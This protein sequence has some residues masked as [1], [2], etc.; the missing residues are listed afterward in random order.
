MAI[1]IKSIT[2]TFAITQIANVTNGKTLP[3]YGSV[4]DAS[5]YFSARLYTE[6]WF[7]CER[8]QQ[9]AALSDASRRIDRLNFIGSRAE[10]GQLLEFPRLGQTF[11]PVQIEQATYELA[12]IMLS[13]VDPDTEAGNLSTVTRGYGSM[14]TEYLRT[15]AVPNVKAGIPSM[16]AWNLLVPYL[17]DGSA[18]KLNR[19]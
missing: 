13:G 11:V 17:R 9:I 3:F 6:D 16:T 5:N 14:K 4:D 2:H 18:V 1:Y 12:L 15:F 7:S 19:V 10:S 8:A